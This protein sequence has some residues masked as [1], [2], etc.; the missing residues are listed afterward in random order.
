MAEVIDEAITQGVERDAIIAGLYDS[1][2]QNY[3]NRVKGTRTVGS[4]IFCQGM[5]FSSPALA[6]AVVRQTGRVVGAHDDRRSDLVGD[7]DGVQLAGGFEPV[8]HP[9]LDGD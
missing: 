3:L 5:P 2:I 1:V 9:A 8:G 7:V 6:A 4:R